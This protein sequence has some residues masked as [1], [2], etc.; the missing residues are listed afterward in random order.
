MR[1]TTAKPRPGLHSGDVIARFGS[2][3]SRFGNP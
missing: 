1:N 2:V 3:I